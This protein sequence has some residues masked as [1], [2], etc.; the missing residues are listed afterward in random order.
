[1]FLMHFR[2]RYSSVETAPK[3]L[4]K[5]I[6]KIDD[7]LDLKFHLQ[8]EKWHVVRYLNTWGARHGEFTKVLT[9]EEDP[10]LEK[11]G[12]L[13]TWLYEYL[14]KCDTHRR[15]ILK[16]IEAQE[17]RR[18]E[19]NKKEIFNIGWELGKDLRKPLLR[20]LDYGL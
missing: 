6:R 10:D 7:R 20:N 5:L 4:V 3:S 2:E 12:F 16:E 9:I 8:S 11:H 13:G 19:S 14:Q 15:N 1:M 17:S 18:E